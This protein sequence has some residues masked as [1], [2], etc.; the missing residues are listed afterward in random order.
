V[1]TAISD[2]HE[3][4]EEARSLLT[5]NVLDNPYALYARLRERAPFLELDDYVIVTRYPHVREIYE[6]GA[7]FHSNHWRPGTAEYEAQRSAI[8]ALDAEDRQRYEEV[9]AFA[10]LLVSQSVGPD[11][12]RRRD[13]FRT[14]FEARKMTRLEDHV[15]SVV[16]RLLATLAADPQADVV[17][18]FAYRVP[19]LTHMHMLG[20]PEVDA[21]LLTDWATRMSNFQGRTD[22]SAVRP[23]HEMLA[24]FRIYIRELV[25][26][27]RDAYAELSFLP[28]LISALDAG[29]IDEWELVGMC[30]NVLLTGSEATMSLIATGIVTFTRHRDQWLSLCEQPGLAAHAV[31]ECLRFEPP[32]QVT[33][34]N[35]LED[36]QL[37]GH[38]LAAGKRVLAMIG[39]ANHDPAIFA[40][41]ERFIISR[42]D[43]KHKLTFATGAHHCLGAVLARMEGRVVFSTLARRYP[44]LELVDG[45][46]E[47]RRNPMV[48]APKV[49]RVAFGTAHG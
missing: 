5:R 29:K 37:G 25:L 4:A 41:P 31:E 15:Q 2:T 26:A 40:M 17:S 49:L 30:A 19:Q 6:D 1:S 11:H 39:A 33:G 38:A 16:D 20:I 48:R 47:W 18:E 42:D 12:R 10:Q 21:P 27:Q 14:A 8:E 46:V 3:L 23:Y 35:V 34:R 44:D 45:R 36:T 13:V 43:T 32:V 7:R 24:E 28:T 22:L 9:A